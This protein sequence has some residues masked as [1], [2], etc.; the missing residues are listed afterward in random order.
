[1]EVCGLR[2]QT[3]NLILWPT[4]RKLLKNPIYLLLVFSQ[5]FHVSRIVRGF[6]QMT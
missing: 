2:L 1:M 3:Y 6:S 5:M 4:W